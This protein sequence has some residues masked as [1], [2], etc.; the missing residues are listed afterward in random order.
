MSRDQ[1]GL[2]AHSV[3]LD[4]QGLGLVSSGEG[5]LGHWKWGP[6]RSPHKAAGQCK[7]M[8]SGATA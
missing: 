2:H 1:P 3:T 4:F 6:W 5:A 7:A 8:G